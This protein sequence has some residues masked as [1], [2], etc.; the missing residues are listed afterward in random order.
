VMQGAPSL[1]LS[2]A[3]VGST[4]GTITLTGSG[5]NYVGGLADITDSTSGNVE[6][7][8]MGAESGHVLALLDLTDAATNND[9]NAL[10][11]ALTGKSGINSVARV[12]DLATQAPWAV[13]MTNSEKFDIVLDLT[14]VGS[15][16]VFV[17]FADLNTL[18]GGTLVLDRVAAI[19]EPTTLALAGMSALGMMAR[20]RRA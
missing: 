18:A 20:R 4:R 2:T 11:T 15:S 3:A 1:A 19:P 9:L 5:G 12:T 16:P 17:N 13:G 14:K 10:V 7:D 8:G 6:I